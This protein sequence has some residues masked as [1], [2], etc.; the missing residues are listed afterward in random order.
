[1]LRWILSTGVALVVVFLVLAHGVAAQE[2]ASPHVGRRP[3]HITADSLEYDKAENVYIARGH[4]HITDGKRTLD[5]DWVAYAAGTQQG[6][7][8]GDVV[9]K[10]GTDTLLADVLNFQANELKGIVY[11]GRLEAGEKGFIATGDEIRRLG[12]DHYKL[13]NATLTTC[14]CPEEKRQPWTIRAKKTDIQV[15]GYATARNTTFEILGVP[16][17]WLPW[18][19]YPVKTER[20]TGFLQP[21]VDAASRNGFGVGLPF[22]WAALPQVNVTITPRYYTKNGFKPEGEV[23]YV[24]GER[25]R[26]DLYGTWVHDQNINPSNPATPFSQN[27]WAVQWRHDQFLPDGWRFRV[28]A[29]AFSDNTYPFDFQDFSRYR[30]DRFI[31]SIAFLENRF[32]ETGQFGF[33]GALQYAADQQNPDNQKRDKFLLQRLPDLRFSEA[34]SPLPVLGGRIHFSFD[35]RYTY[36][37][38]QQRAQSVYPQAQVVGHNQFLDTGIDAIPDGSERNS[39]GQVV[40]GDAHQ[41]D[42]PLAGGTEGDGLFEPGEPLADRGNRLVLNP[43]VSI[44]FQLFDRFEVTPEAGYYGTFYHTVGQSYADRQLATGLLDIRTRL[45]R[46]ISL[47]FGWG[48]AL[49]VLEPRVVWT[50]ISQASQGGDPLFIPRPDV[51]QERLRQLD[52]TSVLRDPSDRV[53]GVDAVTAALSNRFF[54]EPPRRATGAKETDLVAPRLFGDTVLSFQRDFATSSLENLFLDGTLY[55]TSDTYAR[56]NVGWN[57]PDHRLSEALFE[58]MYS[59]AKG[60]DVS[61][62]YRRVVDIPRFFENFRYDNQRFN[63]FSSSLTAINQ[64][65]TYLRWAITPNWALTHNLSYSFEGSLL[66]SNTF[67]V[68]YT[69]RCKCW[70]VRVQA[71]DNRSSGISVGFRYRLIGLGDDTVRPFSRGGGGGAAP[72]SGSPAQ[73]SLASPGAL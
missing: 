69:S 48:K 35:S 49:H 6:L 27:R 17:L 8:T 38:A 20:Q 18:M 45:E 25:S 37:F 70:A 36:F 65:A 46:E 21:Q 16:I 53:A 13:R 66:L 41:D 61:L 22:F 34:D 56:F 57:L 33:T 14:R 5:A 62:T 43:R 40:P 12:T 3:L 58:V 15:G 42:F 54:L 72:F 44:P 52:P 29:K 51:L 9:V 26:G 11:N 55:P 10:D 64:L 73:S 68:E 19:W 50:G 47:P 39:A 71:S 1:M 28:D 67:G 2:A 7:A 30:S 32:G 31:Q 24:F 4:V 63:N 23:E 59:S 60:N